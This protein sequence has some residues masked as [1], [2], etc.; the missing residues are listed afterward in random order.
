MLATTEPSCPG[1][2]AADRRGSAVLTGPGLHRVARRRAVDAPGSSKKRRTPCQANVQHDLLEIM[3]PARLMRRLKPDRVPFSPGIETRHLNAASWLNHRINVEVPPVLLLTISSFVL[4]VSIVAVA[5][6]FKTR[7][8]SALLMF[9][10]IDFPLITQAPRIVPVTP[11]PRVVLMNPPDRTED[12]NPPSARND[13]VSFVP[14]T[15][16]RQSPTIFDEYSASA[17]G[18]AFD[19]RHERSS[20]NT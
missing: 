4:T 10:V 1:W 6:L 18:A 8:S 5:T 3:R 19:G 20:D 9:N 14:P 17:T 2:P 15:S 7:S 11:W 13:M 16:P 12:T